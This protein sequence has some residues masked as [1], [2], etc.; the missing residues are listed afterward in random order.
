MLKIYTKDKCFYCKN[1]KKNLDK[2][3]FQYEEINIEYDT[4]A[5]EYFQSKGYKTVPQL[6][7][8]DKNIQ[9]G[10]STSL[11]QSIIEDRIERV[12]WPGIDGGIE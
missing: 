3:G 1:L 4:E 7:Y 8:R 2:W 10:D 5:A 6:Y 9:N 12:E 11:T